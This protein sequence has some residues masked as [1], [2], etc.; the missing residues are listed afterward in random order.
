MPLRDWQAV[1]VGGGIINGVSQQGVW[2][3]ER[4]KELLQDQPEL[5]KRWRQ[6]LEQAATMAENQKTPPGTRYDA[7]RIIPLAG[8]TRRGEQL[9]KYL[10]QGVDDE[11][12]MGAISG[13]SDIDAPE[14]AP[15][16]VAGHGHFSAENR[17]LAVD[18]L[19]RTEPR[20][21][22]LIEAL[23]K[24]QLKPDDLNEKQI[25]ALRKQKNEK[26][27]TRAEKALSP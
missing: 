9:A 14:V 22:A 13:L 26:L 25:E 20:T 4:M 11:L 2:P 27:R 12:Q 1:V 10:R 15:L 24:K 5:A 7:L 23:E 8:W 6:T 3:A 16:L 21:A 18:A 17:A 19:L